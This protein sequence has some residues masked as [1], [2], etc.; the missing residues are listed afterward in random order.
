MDAVNRAPVERD[1][2]RGVR[3]IGQ[4][5][6]DLVAHD[7]EAELRAQRL[8]GQRVDQRVEALQ[9]RRV[10][11][12]QGVQV[13]RRRAAPGVQHPDREAEPLELGIA[14]AHLGQRLHEPALEVERP[15]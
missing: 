9:D 15:R 11:E 4:R 8:G 3:R 10:V 14:S 1:E 13:G 5:C 2:G 7:D 6:V 12:R